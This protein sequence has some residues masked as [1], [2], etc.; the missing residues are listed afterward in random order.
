MSNHALITGA[1]RGIGA[2]A[3]RLCA[4]EGW[5]VAVHYNASRAAAEQL[6]AELAGLGV[7][8]VPIQADAG[9]LDALRSVRSRLAASGG[10]PAYVVFSNA[11]LADMAARQPASMEEFLEVSGVGEVKA[12]RYGRDFLEAIAEWKRMEAEADS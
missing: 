7:K 9:L 2:A 4:Q 6:A 10:V 11:S 12:Q 3:A 1:S 5:N 8:A